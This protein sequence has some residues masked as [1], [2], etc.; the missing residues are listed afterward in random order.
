MTNNEKNTFNFEMALNELN[1]LVE[2]MEH[3][4]LDLEKSLQH[5]EKGITLIRNCQA[6]LKEAEQKVQ[7]LVAKDKLE[8][9]ETESEA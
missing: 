3:G 2:E 1:T 6:A 8:P 4:D 7:I 9:Y 5:F